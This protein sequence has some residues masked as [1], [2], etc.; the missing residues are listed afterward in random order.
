[1]THL[2]VV[3]LERLFK[4][5]KDL[6]VRERLLMV[7]KFTEGLSSYEVGRQLHCP[8]SKVL[9]W[10]YRFEEE[11]GAQRFERPP[12]LRKAKE[13]HGGPGDKNT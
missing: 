5:E 4:K 9:Y 12:A 3:E 11:E 1:M 6:K 2:E 8:H 10:K 7:L 13:H